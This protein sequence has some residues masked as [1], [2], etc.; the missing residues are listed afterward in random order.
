VGYYFVSFAHNT[1]SFYLYELLETHWYI[2]V[3]EEKIFLK[4][5]MSSQSLTEIFMFGL[6]IQC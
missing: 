2:I 6:W 1:S 4:L 5:N 3:F